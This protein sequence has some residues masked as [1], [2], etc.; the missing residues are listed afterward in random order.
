MVKILFNVIKVDKMNKSHR[1]LTVLIITVLALFTSSCK[2]LFDLDKNPDIS[3]L[4]QGFKTSAAIGYCTSL[5]VMAFEG[6]DLPSNVRYEKGSSTAYSQAGILYVNFDANNRLPFNN[7]IGQVIVSGVWD[8]STE[9]GVVNIIFGDLNIFDGKYKFYGIHT[10]PVR[11][12]TGSEQFITVFAQ[13]DVV[14]GEGSDTLLQVG[15]ST[16]QFNTEIERLDKKPPTDVFVA[17]QQNV[18]FLKFYQN[19]AADVYDDDIEINGGGQIA[20]ASNTGGGVKYHA[21]IETKYNYSNCNRNP[22][23]GS[24]FIQDIGADKGIDLG[25][26]SMDFRAECEGKAKV[27]FAS[28]DY[29]RANGKNMDLNF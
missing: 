3:P 9:S 29:V 15:L 16:I 27:T 22:S 12:E 17:A 1:F 6:E 2:K 5:A 19:N 10:V 13:Q 8:N 25:T 4:R 26:I 7:H 23:K 14:I 24:G 28:G 20:S 11:R 21:L 18:W